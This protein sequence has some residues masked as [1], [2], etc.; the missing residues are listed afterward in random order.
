MAEDEHRAMVDAHVADTFARLTR[1][2]CAARLRAANTAFGFVNDVAGLARHPALRRLSVATP[3][4]PV[5]VA[6][7]PARFSDGEREYGPVPALGEHTE[8]V[9]AEFAA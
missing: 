6:A 1:T 8:Q 5:D 7:P 2:E 9:R 4:G 3:N